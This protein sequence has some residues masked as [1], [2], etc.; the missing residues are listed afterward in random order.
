MV[1]AFQWIDPDGVAT[2]LTISWDIDGRFMPPVTYSNDKLPA[3][4][5]E[6]VRHVRFEARPVK[7]TGYLQANCVSAD[8]IADVYAQL[9]SLVTAMNP[10]RGMGTLRVT[11]A[12]GQQRD[13]HCYYQ[14][15]LELP[16]KF[17]DTALRRAH[18][19]TLTLM[20]FDPYWYATGITQLTFNATPAVAFFPFFP[21]RLTSSQI[22]VSS[23]VTNGGA[24]AWPVW[25]IY[26]PGS[27]ILLSNLDTGEKIDLSN[28]TGLAIAGGDYIVI[29]TTPGVKTITRASTGENLWPYM[30]PDSTLWPIP[31]NGAYVELQ[32]GGT[33]TGVSVLKLT[34]TT[35]YLT[36]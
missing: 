13:L 14:S 6:T 3:Y 18:K 1:Q 19:I 36:V 21:L 33:T 11:N 12:A 34:Y 27:S 15:G 23:F 30:T 20:A 9:V 29:D 31:A 28:G 35:R 24:E 2:N 22:V 25:T 26:G 8:P 4:D 10:K 32:M 17:G 7:I 16:E 5:G